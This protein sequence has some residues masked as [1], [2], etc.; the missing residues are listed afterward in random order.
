MSLVFAVDDELFFQAQSRVNSVACLPL[1][2]G[3]NSFDR[4]DLRLFVPLRSVGIVLRLLT[5]VRLVG[6]ERRQV[7]ASGRP[8]LLVTF[9]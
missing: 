3:P 7:V 6:S 5:F 1:P 8:H 4:R 9:V 2:L